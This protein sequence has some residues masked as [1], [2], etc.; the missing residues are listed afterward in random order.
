MKRLNAKRAPWLRAAVV[1]TL[2]ACAFATLAGCTAAP[3]VEVESSQVQSDF[4]AFADT[5]SDNLVQS[6]YVD[7]GDYALTA[8]DVSDSHVADDGA[9][10]FDAT[11]TF[12]NGSFRTTMDVAATY[13][14]DGDSYTPSF[15]VSNTSTKAI[16]GIKYDPQGTLGASDSENVKSIDFD[17]DAQTCTVTAAYEPEWF[18]SVQG[19]VEYVY[20]FDGATWAPDTS[21]NGLPAVSYG[22]LV[23]T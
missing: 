3:K 9:N 22:P 2:V 11:A 6:P 10:V 7:N 15:E 4:E 20:R 8:F 5:L 19:D 18:E 21:A 23:A 16:S 1:I 12:E 17:E 14:K 13:A